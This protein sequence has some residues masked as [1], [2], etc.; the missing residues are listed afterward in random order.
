MNVVFSNF[1]SSNYD[2][3]EELCAKLRCGGRL[4]NPKI[5]EACLALFD[6]GYFR[7]VVIDIT[8]R[9]YVVHF[10]DFGNNTETENLFK[11]N[12]DLAKVPRYA[13]PIEF[14]REMSPVEESIIENL[15]SSETHELSAQVRV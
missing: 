9:S 13:I 8:D 5:N 3:R 1:W 7:A 12:P 2:P 10:V 6:G 15:L 4:P 14:H 11:M